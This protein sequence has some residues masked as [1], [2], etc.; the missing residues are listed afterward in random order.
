MRLTDRSILLSLALAAAACGPGPPEAAAPPADPEVIAVYR[1]GQV[2]R[3]DVDRAVLALP[4]ALRQPGPE[5]TAAEWYERVV[6]ELVIDRLLAGEAELLAGGDDPE[7]AA[8]RREGRRQVVAETWLERNPPAV[9]A[10]TESDVRRYY[11]Q[12]PERYDRRGRRLVSHLFKRRPPGGDVTGLRQ[13][14]AELRRRALAG[15]S[16]AALAAEHSDSESRHRGGSLGWVSREQLAPQLVEVI[17]SLPEEVP[18]EPLTTAE[19]VHLFQVE[20]IVEARRFAFDEVAATIE[21][22]LRLERR[23]EALDRLAAE[24]PQPADSFVAGGEELEALL[25]AGDPEATVLRIGDYELT[26]A[27]LRGLL[28]EQAAAGQAPVDAARL[29]HGVERRERIYRRATSEGLADD[30]EVAARLARRERRDLLRILRQRSLGRKLTAEPERLQEY[31]DGNRLRFSSPL[32]L[33]VRRLTVPVDAAAA[34]RVMARL[35]RAAAGTASGA[36]RLASLAAELGGEV[37]ELG[38]RSLAELAR[39]DPRWRSRAAGLGAGEL[40][41]PLSAASSLEMLEVTARREPEPLP[42]AAVIERVRAAYLAAHRQELY[43]EWADG[44]LAD[45]GLEIFRDR[46]EGLAAGGPPA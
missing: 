32:R 28:E 25:A 15:E 16:F 37:E 33:E 34:D 45:A 40:S 26:A 42:F 46:L 31:Y 7:V 12:H 43:R 10:V 1:D 20:K 24:L 38:W 30:P 4:A 8:A 39:L 44:M 9:A 21:R 17:F 35:E 5:E 2:T 19:G 6:R 3:G 29:L 11:D 27:R 36:D 41:P 23:D 14:V 13:E 18:S 22:Q